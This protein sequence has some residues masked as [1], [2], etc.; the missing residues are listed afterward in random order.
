MALAATNFV[1]VK[2]DF[3]FNGGTDIIFQHTSG[4]AIRVVA[5]RRLLCFQH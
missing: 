4:S 1:G 3:N 5:Q 2:G